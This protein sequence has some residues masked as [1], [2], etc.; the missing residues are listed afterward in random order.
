MQK[1]LRMFPRSSPAHGF[2]LVE[3][4]IVVLIIGI[5]LAIAIPNFIAARESAR[6]KACVSNLQ[7]IYS[8]K[9]EAI[10]D[11]KLTDPSL[12]TFSLDGVT[13]TTSGPTGTYQL[14]SGSSGMSYIHAMPVC[15]SGG[16]YTVSAALPL[17][18]CSITGAVGS[19]YAPTE[20]WYH[21]IN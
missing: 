1:K 5:L 3:I 15:P 13:P 6:A 10:M 4:M 17:P 20:K 19:G 18:I 16:Q 9:Q 21:G 14:V 8:A 2:T 7:E 11:Y 12:A